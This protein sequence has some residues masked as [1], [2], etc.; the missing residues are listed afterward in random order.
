V[1]KM[2]T[3]CLS[4]LIC[5][6]GAVP[7]TSY[8][9]ESS[10]RISSSFI[11]NWYCRD[12]SPE[13]WEQEFTAAGE[14]G[15]ESLILQS[16][17]DIVRGEC[18]GEKHDPESYPSAE[19]FCIFPSAVKADYHSSQNGGDALELALRAAKAADMKL[20]IGTV[21]D[22]MWWNYGW[23]QPDS[24]FVDW[25]GDNAKLSSSLIAEI[26]QRYGDEY[27]EQIA[28]WY[29]TNEVWN[30]DAAC[31]GSDGGRY[32]EIIGG[33]IRECLESV[34][35]SC[36]EK[37]VMISPFY[38]KDLSSPQQFGDFMTDLI[39]RSGFR[40]DDIYAP[41]DGG[42]RDYPPEVIRQWAVEQ[43]SAVDGRMRFLIN[44]EC[45]GS[46]LKAMP[47]ESFV[48]NYSATAD[49]GEGHIIFSWNHYY[50]PDSGLNRQFTE[51]NTGAVSGDVNGDGSFNVADLVLFQRRLLAVSGAE[52]S[53]SGAADMCRDGI[54]DVF[55]LCAM[56]RA[57]IKK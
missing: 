41:Q 11:Q 2:L 12:W 10:P 1:K 17:Y 50:A 33:N 13:R 57:L 28:G 42:G 55:D 32:A 6:T 16:S 53:D 38:N 56:R 45:F 47:V 23:G 36:P 52:L 3:F 15:F 43:K 29:Y 30:I 21:S 39:Y 20:W 27:G 5:C 48:K 25:C 7:M 34:K 22:D 40:F 24:Y 26:W 14:A 9:A 51:F 31:E 49:L 18:R 44:H 35:Q 46:E 8:S 4:A 37:P 54:L 19:S